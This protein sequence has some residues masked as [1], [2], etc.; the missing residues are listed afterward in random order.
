MTDEARAR[1]RELWVRLYALRRH[2]YQ[3]T[4][5]DEIDEK[6]LQEILA[7]FAAIR[8]E[9]AYGPRGTTMSESK[10]AL[11]REQVEQLFHDARNY[12]GEGLDPR[13]KT[14]LAH[15]A[16]LRAKLDKAV[17]SLELGGYTDHDGE[18]WKPP[19]WN[20]AELQAK[21]EELTDTLKTY[22]QR[23]YLKLKELQ[24]KVT[25]LERKRDEWKARYE[26]EC[27]VTER[28]RYE[29]LQAIRITT[30]IVEALKHELK[31]AVERCYCCYSDIF[32][33]DW[34]EHAQ[35]ALQQ[36]EAK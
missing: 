13:F 8:E 2:G 14:L 11:T 28:S 4:V 12:G 5:F 26:A 10:S 1:A 16:A 21:V 33:K 15:D 23:D 7:A 20:R 25:A 27:A 24:A 32:R 3:L 18:L 34:K 22:D 6:C 30:T 9:C 17:R 35:H 31:V 36:A 19:L 29:D